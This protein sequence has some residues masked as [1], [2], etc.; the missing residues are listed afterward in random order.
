MDVEFIGSCKYAIISTSPSYK[1]TVRKT[2][3]KQLKKPR[4]IIQTNLNLSK[5]SIY[6][7]KI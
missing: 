5:I 3:L 7:P 4:R 1:E 6:N 2:L